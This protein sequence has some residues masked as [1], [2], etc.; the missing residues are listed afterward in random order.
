[1]ALTSILLGLLALTVAAS[2]AAAAAAAAADSASPSAAASASQDLNLRPVI[3]ILSQELSRSMRK[4]LTDYDYTSY[5]AASYVKFFEGA[6]ARVVPILINQDDDYYRTMISSINGLVFPGGSA[7]ITQRSGY[8]RAG[9]LLYDLLLE[10]AANGTILPLFATCLGFEMLMYLHANNTNPL[11]SCKAQNLSDPLFLQTGWELSE[12]LGEAPEN[13]VQTLTTTNATSN[14]HKYCVTPQ[15]FRDLGLD[16]DFLMAVDVVDG[17]IDTWSKVGIPSSSCSAAWHPE[18]WTIISPGICLVPLTE[19]DIK[20]CLLD[21]PFSDPSAGRLSHI[22]AANSQTAPYTKADQTAQ[23]AERLAAFICCVCMPVSVCLCVYIPVSLCLYVSMPV[24]LCLF[25]SM[26]LT[27]QNNQNFGSKEKEAA[28]L[29][30]NH[31]PTYISQ[32]YRSSFQQCY[33]FE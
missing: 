13:I 11:T 1:M 9:R 19:E 18:K 28:M 27:R 7:S 22:E 33:F 2:P 3:G 5:I 12:L 21:V 8:G 30:Y 29:I 20:R 17:R 15:T 26:Y 24:S 14:F 16:E 6:G 10:S 32:L 23:V 31:S 25:V 4:A